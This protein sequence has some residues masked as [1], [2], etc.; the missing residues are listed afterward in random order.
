MAIHGRLLMAAGLFAVYA[1]SVQAA[2][3]R[4]TPLRLDFSPQQKSGQ[5]EVANLGPAPIAVQVKAFRWTQKDGA[6]VYEPTSDIFFAPPIISVA[7]QKKNLVRFRLRAAPPVDQ[8]ITYRV[9]FQ[10]VPPATDQTSGSG[11][12]FRVR[13]GVPVF[14]HP[15][16]PAYP[17]LAASLAREA[18]GLRVTLKNTGRAHARIEDIQLYPLAT[19]PQK[20]DQAMVAHA[21]QSTHQTNYLLPGT[22]DEW[23]LPLAAGADPA[24]L[25]VLV[26]TDD[27]SGHAA[28]GI[29]PQ[30]WWWLPPAAG[31]DSPARP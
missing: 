19:D 21:P 31:A 5:V 28:P 25:K 13:F 18:D 2:G 14:L 16:K 29:T 20:L 4:V 10:E 8:E 27:Y 9:Y 12:T 26:R 23:L 11:M 7:S 22:A 1:G 17:V 24:G 6:D 30:G 15:L 3:L